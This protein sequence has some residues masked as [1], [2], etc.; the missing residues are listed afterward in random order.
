M[1]LHVAHR[2]AVRRAP[3]ASQ[4]RFR[5]TRAPDPPAIYPHDSGRTW[6]SV[7]AISHASQEHS[8]EARIVT[9]RPV[10]MQGSMWSLG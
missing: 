9:V 10:S 1:R 2:R 3:A 8:R 4:R 5:N 6:T 7:Q